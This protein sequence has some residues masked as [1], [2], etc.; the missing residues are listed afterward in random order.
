MVPM[1]G[2]DVAQLRQLAQTFTSSADTIDRISHEVTPALSNGS[3]KGG[4]AEHFRNEWSST[5]QPSLAASSRALAESAT[6]LQRNADEQERASSTDGS[7][8]GGGGGGNGGPGGGGPGGGGQ[9]K[10]SILD[11]LSDAK[12]WITAITS[13]ITKS[14][15][16]KKIFDLMKIYNAADLL[17]DINRAAASAKVFLLDDMVNLALGR[18]G[19]M[20]NMLGK[21]GGVGTTIGRWLGP[22]GGVFSIIGGF[23]DMIDPSHDGWRGMGDRVAGLLSVGSGVGILALAAGV[24]AGPVTIAAIVGAGVVAGVWTLGN[25][26]WDNREAI[27]RFAS[28]VWNGAGDLLSSA[29][30]AVSSA[31]STV[32][33]GVSKG[34]GKVK[35]WIGGLFS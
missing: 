31:A 10:K 15:T 2:A 5:I 3:W 11:W 6:V 18:T 17:S 35:D 26:I 28:G 1:I 16:L 23:K 29:G 9:G 22:I 27:G 8:G 32:A 7:T 12:E 33:D 30:N 14:S 19:L 24:A 4:D 25:M 21:L 13:P 34:A 20:A